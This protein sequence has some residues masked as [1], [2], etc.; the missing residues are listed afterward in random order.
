MSTQK[1]YFDITI[2]IVM[3]L[4]A[5]TVFPLLPNLAHSQQQRQL[6]PFLPP[7]NTIE[8]QIN[9]DIQNESNI[10]ASDSNSNP[11]NTDKVVILDFYDNDIASI[12]SI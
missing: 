2:T 1:G 9:N 3:L 12:N 11:I 10:S 7:A 6:F 5:I 4:F 8:G